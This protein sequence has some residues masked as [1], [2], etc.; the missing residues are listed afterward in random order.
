M[1]SFAL[2]ALTILV[3]TFIV[4]INANVPIQTKHQDLPTRADVSQLDKQ[5]E[6]LIESIASDMGQIQKQVADLPDEIAAVHS[7]FNALA[8]RQD[9]FDQ[10]LEALEAKCE[11]CNS[12]AAPDV[13]AKIQSQADMLTRLLGRI[14]KLESKGNYQS[15]G[16]S[17]GYGSSGGST[18]RPVQQS[19]YSTGASNQH[20]T[21]PGDLS[22][23]LA[24]S[25]GVN[26]QGMSHSEQLALHD[27]IHKST[28]SSTSTQSRPP[29]T[30]LPPK[31]STQTT[32]ASTCPAGTVCPNNDGVVVQEQTR[33]GWFGRFKK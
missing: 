12:V 22:S 21:Y 25:H 4:N 32:G 13:S 2:A 17:V 29:Q 31:S 20:W 18:G 14:E 26:T 1:K 33:R 3:G 6:G 24:S 19:I 28:S 15:V 30:P 5:F 9:A 11:S 27:S 23:H 8:N 10:R 7:S 16:F